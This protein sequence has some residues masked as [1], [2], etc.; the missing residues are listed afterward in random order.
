ALKLADANERRWPISVGQARFIA[1]RNLSVLAG[2][3]DGGEAEFTRHQE[4]ALKAWS[5][6]TPQDDALELGPW[7]PPLAPGDPGVR[8]ELA[9][10]QDHDGDLDLV[11]AGRVGGVTGLWTYE[12]HTMPG[13][14]DGPSLT[15]VPHEKVGLTT[16]TTAPVVGL[17]AG[18][19]DE[20]ND[21]DVVAFS[22]G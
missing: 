4:A 7:V 12:N 11:V 6:P 8:E 1:H 19:L 2:N 21:L 9:V 18:D 13:A 16:P 5:G 3:A 22:R 20:G 15:R 14:T 17:A 10:D